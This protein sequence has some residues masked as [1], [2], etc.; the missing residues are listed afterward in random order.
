MKFIK[1]DG[2][3]ILEIHEFFKIIFDEKYFYE[4]NRI[5]DYQSNNK[6]AFIVH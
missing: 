6:K 4:D 1:S 3:Y 2:K 5:N